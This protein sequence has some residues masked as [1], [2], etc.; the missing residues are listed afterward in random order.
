MVGKIVDDASVMVSEVE[1]VAVV[2]GN[3]DSEVVNDGFV[4]RV[5]ND[6]GGHSVLL[7]N[8]LEYLL[9]DEVDPAS[10][11]VDAEFELVVGLVVYPV[12]VMVDS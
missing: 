7:D 6:V 1:S 8:V 4:V 9:E 12:C 5:E 3:S 11:I 10:E 2:I